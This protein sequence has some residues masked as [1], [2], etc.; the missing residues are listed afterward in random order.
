M[1][2]KMVQFDEEGEKRRSWKE[3]WHVE[4]PLEFTL[5]KCRTSEQFFAFMTKETSG[6][7][8]G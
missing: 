2:V 5:L 7:Y 3:L 6:G 4:L 8:E 1:V